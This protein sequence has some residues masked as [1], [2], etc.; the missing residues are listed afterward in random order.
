MFRIPDILRRIRIL[1]SVQWILD[2]KQNQKVFA[3][4]RYLIFLL[5]ALLEGFG[6]GSRSYTHDPATSLTIMFGSGWWLRHA[7]VHSATGGLPAAQRT[8]GAALRVGNGG[9]SGPATAGP[10]F[11]R[12]A[13]YELSGLLITWRQCSGFGRICKFLDHPDPL[14]RCT[15]P[16]HSIIK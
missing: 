6:S 14:V 5:V 7:S 10:C 12:S 1:G 15:D 9:G 2:P 16:D 8:H 4:L 11:F 3:Y 13:C